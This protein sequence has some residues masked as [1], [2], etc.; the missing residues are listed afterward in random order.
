M[1]PKYMYE[2]LDLKRFD[3]QAKAEEAAKNMEDDEE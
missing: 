2:E 3:D 1:V